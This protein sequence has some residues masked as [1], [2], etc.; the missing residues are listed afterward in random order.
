M[1]FFCL[2]PIFL[3]FTCSDTVSADVYLPEKFSF[4][5]LRQ[6]SNPSSHA[7]NQGNLSASLPALSTLV[8][9]NDVEYFTQ[10]LTS[11]KLNSFSHSI[12]DNYL[13][14]V[15]IFHKPRARLLNTTA[16]G[17]NCLFHNMFI[18]RT[19]PELPN[20]FIAYLNKPQYVSQYPNFF[21]FFFLTKRI[22]NPLKCLK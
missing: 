21:F 11:A 13:N 3:F 16:D 4:D 19:P 1:S 18:G 15:S 10:P 17:A 9:G 20:P 14:Q 8:N 12:M 22:K 6:R 5:I 2:R 7:R